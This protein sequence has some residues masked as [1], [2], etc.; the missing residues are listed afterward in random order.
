[1][2]KEKMVPLL[3]EGFVLVIALN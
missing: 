1:M 2:G 3:E